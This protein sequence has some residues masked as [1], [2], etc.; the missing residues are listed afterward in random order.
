[1]AIIEKEY[2]VGIH[3]VGVLGVITNSGI[4]NLF[5][6]IACS[7]S[8]SAGYGLMQIPQTHL[9]WVLLN[10]KV[11]VLKRVKYGT[12]VTLKTWARAA[13]SF[14]T[15]RD[16]EMYDAQNHLVCIASTKWTLIDINKGG[17]IRIPADVIGTYEPLDDRKVFDEDDIK[18]IKEPELPEKPSFVFQVQRR[19]IDVNGHM[20]NLYYL[21]YAYE[22]LPQDIYEKAEMNH[23]EIMYKS[24]AKLGNTVA[25]YYVKQENC[26]YVVM[27]NP[28]T[29]TLHAIVKLYE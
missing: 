7:H 6:D 17:M 3:D 10:W 22:T 27:K 19:D 9:S 11:S 5:E 2:T 29:N 23:F 20:H 13:T 12:K 14:F 16:F 4:I 15:L 24:G 28:E 21:D 26:H 25:C 8:D 18:K 1:M